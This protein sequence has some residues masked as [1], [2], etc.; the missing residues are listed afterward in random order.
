MVPVF[1][2]ELIFACLQSLGLCNISKAG[3][4]WEQPM[5]ALKCKH[6]WQISMK[7]ALIFSA[8]AHAPFFIA[9]LDFLKNTEV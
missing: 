8:H 2:R 6:E 7:T 5:Q 9:W 4:P 1:D 3:S